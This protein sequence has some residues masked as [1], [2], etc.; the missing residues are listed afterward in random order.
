MHRIPRLL[1]VLLLAALLAACGAKGD[2]VKPASD[3]AE[4]APAAG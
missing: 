1:P 3:P 2:L 4:T